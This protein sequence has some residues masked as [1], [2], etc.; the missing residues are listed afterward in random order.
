MI[1][2]LGFCILLFLT[3][4]STMQEP[5]VLALEDAKDFA[6]E[7]RRD[8]AG[9]WPQEFP[10]GFKYMQYGLDYNA[11]V[12]D[13]LDDR[14]CAVALRMYFWMNE[15]S[16][17]GFPQ[18]FDYMAYGLDRN[19]R[20]T[21]CWDNPRCKHELMMYTRV[22]PSSIFDVSSTSGQCLSGKYDVGTVL[23]QKAHTIHVELSMPTSFN[24]QSRQW[25]LNLGQWNTGAHHWIWNS[26]KKIQFGRWAGKQIQNVNI[27]SCD[28][29][30]MVVDP[31]TGMKLFCNGKQVGTYSGVVP[32][33]IQNANLAIAS[34]FKGCV[35]HVKIWNMALADFNVKQ[36]SGTGRRS[37]TGRLI[38]MNLKVE[39]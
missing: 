19:A 26:N 16:P 4:A 3:N 32:F 9:L 36:I 15:N 27:L 33:D 34:D 11:R 10:P 7:S 12:T 38:D 13:C 21:D 24:S 25:I 37:L 17:H 30:T 6:S 35:K 2:S 1:T 22:G 28:S 20:V 31:F 8:L 18:G 14:R 5:F 39:N 29:L 23:R